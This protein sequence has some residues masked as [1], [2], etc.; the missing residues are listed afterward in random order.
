MDINVFRGVLAVICLLAFLGI[1]AWAW[2]G[3]QRER[4]AEAANLPFVEPD[5]A[6]GVQERK[7]QEQKHH[8]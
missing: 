3:R 4:F 1:V 7:Y 2:S 6:P 5:D 8:G